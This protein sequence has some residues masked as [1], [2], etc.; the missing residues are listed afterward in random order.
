MDSKSTEEDSDDAI[1]KKQLD[2]EVGYWRYVRKAVHATEVR[3]KE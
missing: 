1:G 2:F 3:V